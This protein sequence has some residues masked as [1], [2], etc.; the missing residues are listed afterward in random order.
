M[1]ENRKSD[2]EGLVKRF[3]LAV[4]RENLDVVSQR[5][6]VSR[7]R[8]YLESRTPEEELSDFFHRLANRQGTFMADF[9]TLY[10]QKS[11]IERKLLGP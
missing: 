2:I 3:E 4:E 11:D 6:L 7:F 9:E 5:E 10:K 1:S 8:S